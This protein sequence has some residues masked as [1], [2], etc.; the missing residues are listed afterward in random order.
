M[1][2]WLFRLFVIGLI[3]VGGYFYPPFRLNPTSGP[4]PPSPW[5]P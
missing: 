2:I 5:A 3:T 4:P 1:G